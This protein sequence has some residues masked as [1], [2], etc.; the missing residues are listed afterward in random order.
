MSTA[1]KKEK[2]PAIVAVMGHV[3]HGKSTLLDYIRKSNVV[4]GEAGGITQHVSAYEAEVPTEE[5]GKKTITFLDTPGHEAFSE[6][7]ARGAVAADIAILVVAADDGVNAQTKEAH[8]EIE[9]AGIPFVVA[10]NKIDLTQ[11]DIGSAKNS[12]VEA[13]IYIE[14]YGGEIPVVEI[15][16]KTGQG[17]DDLLSMLV[18][19]SELEDLSYDKDTPAVGVVLEANIDEQ[20]GT[21]ATLIIKDGTIR[22]GQFVV[23]GDSLAPTRIME[24]FA[25]RGQ[26]EIGAGR[27]ARIVGFSSL[28]K[29]G[30][31]FEVVTT[32]KEAEEK[33]LEYAEIAQELEKRGLKEVP[34]GKEAIPLVIKTDTAGTRDAVLGELEKISHERAAFLVLE[35]STGNI[36][37]SDIKLAGSSG[38]GVVIGFCST[39]DKNAKH[40]SEQTGVTVKT[41]NII[42]ELTEWLEEAIADRAPKIDVE[43]TTGKA[44]ILKIFSKMKG[45]LVIGARCE[46]GSLKKGDVIKLIRRENE[47]ERGK[48]LEL[49][50]GKEEVPKINEGEEFGARIESKLELVPGDHIESFSVVRK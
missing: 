25:L 50:R 15:S 4:A 40:L 1:R 11:A 18:L 7:R 10:I 48:I 45:K 22:S 8:K 41:F 12:L 26:K 29:V 20:K 17:V 5:G 28:P 46:E 21:S 43:E 34:E 35:A 14:G 44:K 19:V 27:P 30:E 16:A 23:A 38:K 9:K 37:E 3:D 31:T 13:G 39:P 2:R 6:M 47:I 36:G 33:V 24:D 32:K 42:Y 49:R